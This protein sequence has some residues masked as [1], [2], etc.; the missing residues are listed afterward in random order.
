MSRRTLLLRPL[1]AHLLLELHAAARS[2]RPLPPRAP[3]PGC[4]C[5]TCATLAA[6]GDW[7]DAADVEDA[8][9]V[10]AGLHPEPRQYPNVDRPLSRLDVARELVEAARR[11]KPDAKWPRPEVLAL[12]AAHAPGAVQE[13]E[14][15]DGCE[16]DGCASA[17]A[18]PAARRTA[19]DGVARRRWME[20]VERARA[21][22][23]AEVAA[24]LGLE[25]HPRRPDWARCP[26]HDDAH[27][28]LH[29]NDH[30]SR[31]YCNPCGRSWDAIELYRE[32]RR[33]TFREAV[34][35]LAP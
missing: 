1:S 2:G 26:F 22:P 3:V 21:T 11:R 6:G 30:K 7:T 25:R 35:E 28:S 9:Q 14:R 19:R 10:L 20:R 32:A 12:L 34:E 8:V 23:L 33:C 27:P 13:G 29:L 24:R 15:V 17:P 18:V 16:C 31:A 5:P 4:A